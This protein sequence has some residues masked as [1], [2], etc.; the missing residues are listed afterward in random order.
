MG[1]RKQ[2]EWPT[3]GLSYCVRFLGN[4]ATSVGA[5]A[6]M[7]LAEEIANAAINIPRA[8]IASMYLNGAMGFSMMLTTLF[9]FGEAENVL[10]TNYIYPFIQI[11]QNA[12]RNIAGAT[13]MG[14]IV[15]AL[16]WS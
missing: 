13:V 5:D 12:V 7:H 10:D 15:I 14:A 11:F 1:P 16:T 2:G 4:G 9:C 6:S 3:Q 8:I